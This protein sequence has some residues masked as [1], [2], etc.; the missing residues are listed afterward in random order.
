[1][2][3]FGTEIEKRVTSKQQEGRSSSTTTTVAHGARRVLDP[4][5][6]EAIRTGYLEVLGP[7]NSIKAHD[8]ERAIAF[9]LDASAILDAIYQTAMAN[10]PTHAY[11]R[12]ILNRYITEGIYTE[13]DAERDRRDYAAR[14]EAANRERASWYSDPVEEYLWTKG[15]VK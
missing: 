3:E 14:R 5:D 13:A 8:I 15:V 7:L 1:M 10:R 12:A 11:L 6:Y 2:T 9:G 4:Q